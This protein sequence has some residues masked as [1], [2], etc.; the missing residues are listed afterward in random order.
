MEDI[1]SIYTG[2]HIPERAAKFKPIKEQLDDLWHD[3]DNGL[4]GESVK[5]GAF[6]VGIKAIKDEVPKG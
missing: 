6:Y 1:Q 2:Q 4:F 3:I 5:T